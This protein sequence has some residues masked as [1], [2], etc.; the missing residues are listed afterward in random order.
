MN[1]LHSDHSFIRCFVEHPRKNR[2]GARFTFERI[3]QVQFRIEQFVRSIC[4]TPVNKVAVCF[5]LL[6]AQ[7]EIEEHQNL[8][9][10]LLEWF[11]VREHTSLEL[12]L[13][14]HKT[15]RKRNPQIIF[16]VAP[17]CLNLFLHP[18]KKKKIVVKL[19][20]LL[21]HI[22]CSGFWKPHS[23]LSQLCSFCHPK[24]KEK[25]HA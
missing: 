24:L 18:L 23:C 17:K 4:S 9:I 10:H 19:F 14:H 11:A 13:F 21:P 22:L 5:T 2:R 16:R 25:I 12:L 8:H 3:I 6:S 1:S 20:A 7:R 15:A